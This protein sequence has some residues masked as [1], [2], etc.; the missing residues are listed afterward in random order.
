MENHTLT[1][2]Y[3]A[4]ARLSHAG[5]LEEALVLL[6]PHLSA[7]NT[8]ADIK[9]SD[10]FHSALLLLASLDLDLE[11]LSASE[12]LLSAAL[13]TATPAQAVDLH[14]LR[15]NLYDARGHVRKAATERAAALQAAKSLDEPIRLLVQVLCS[16]AS[17]D[18]EAVYKLALEGIAVGSTSHPHQV[19]RFQHL[20]AFAAYNI[21]RY[22]DALLWVTKTIV[23]PQATRSQQTDCLRLKSLCVSLEGRHDEGL[24]HLKAATYIARTGASWEY[25]THLALDTARRLLLLGRLTD[26]DDLAQ[27]VLVRFPTTIREISL[28][29]ATI[30]LTR[31]EL[32]KAHEALDM[33]TRSSKRRGDRELLIFALAREEGHY[34]EALSALESLLQHTTCAPLVYQLRL[35]RS[36]VLWQCGQTSEAEKE[37]AELTSQFTESLPREIQAAFYR[38]EAKLSYLREDWVAGIVK[39]KQVLRLEPHPVNQPENWTL[40][41]DGYAQLGESAAAHFAW[42]R[43][44]A[45][46]VESIWVRRAK[47]RLEAS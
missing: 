11:R 12:K 2:A 22:E 47:E 9:P 3:A 35:Q 20:A 21:G 6:E 7:P 10:E 14:L 45:Q 32:G 33:A 42:D 15:G 31:G 30:A 39:W 5:K 16:Q 18:F 8:D 27:E 29:R 46:P 19:V 44:A 40:L 43:A 37:Q 38:M 25:A 26:A 36:P 4:A 23:H 13:S 17:N 1:A 34:P 41:G 28:L 24:E